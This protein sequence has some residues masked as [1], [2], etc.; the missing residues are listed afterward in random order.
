MPVENS[1]FIRHCCWHPAPMCASVLLSPRVS[2]FFLSRQEVLEGGDRMIPSTLRALYHTASSRGPF[3]LASAC[4]WLRV[5]ASLSNWKLIGSWHFLIL[6]YRCL[7][8]LKKKENK[9]SPFFSLCFHCTLAFLFSSCLCI[10][11]LG[12]KLRGKAF[13]F[14]NGKVFCEEDFLVSMSPSSAS[15]CRPEKYRGQEPGQAQTT[16]GGFSLHCPAL[17][18]SHTARGRDPDDLREMLE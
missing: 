12:R 4:P 13:Y 1:S 17:L 5:M 15:L 2:G 9:I 6:V 16:G 18:G 14:V 10:F 11:P 8:L 3:L 7:F